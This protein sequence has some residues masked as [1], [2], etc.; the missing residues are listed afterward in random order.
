MKSDSGPADSRPIEEA[1]EN[2]A[3]EDGVNEHMRG[4]G[5]HPV[6][7]GWRLG[8]LIAAA[9]EVVVST[10]QTTEVCAYCPVVNPGL[11]LHLQESWGGRH[12]TLPISMLGP[13]GHTIAWALIIPHIDR[14]NGYQQNLEDS[15]AEV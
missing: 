5:A 13:T 7:T 9:Y 15:T 4:V 12:R 1:G 6:P 2:V 8:F 3:P 10:G 14:T 11:S